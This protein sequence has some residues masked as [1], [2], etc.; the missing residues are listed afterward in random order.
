M[1][2]AVHEMGIMER[3]VV[4]EFDSLKKALECYGSPEYK[5]ALKALGDGAQRDFRFV[6]GVA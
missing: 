1:P 4:V 5:E 3:V 6:E 2:A